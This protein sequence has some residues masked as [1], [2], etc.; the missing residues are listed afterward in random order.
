M[1]RVFPII[2]LLW[3][4][5]SL[6][7][8]CLPT[9][10]AE[11]DVNNMRVGL[12]NG[13]DMWWD[14][15]VP[16]CEFPKAV[17]IGSAYPKTIIDC[18][19]LWLSGIDNKLDLRLVAQVYRNG[20]DFFPGA[21]SQPQTT[22]NFFNR[23]FKISNDSVAFHIALVQANNGLAPPQLIPKQIIEWPARGNPHLAAQGQGITN[24][25]APFEDTD[26]NGIYEPAK[27]DYPLVKG[28]EAFWCVINDAG[29]HTST[30][31]LSM[32]VEV[33]I[34]AYAFS[35]NG[36]SPLNDATFYEY[37]VT[38]KSE[39]TYN[40]FYVSKWIAVK[41]WY[42][43]DSYETYV[44]CDSLNDLAFWSVPKSPMFFAG[45]KILGITQNKNEVKR[46]L[47]SFLVY[48][49]ENSGARGMPVSA[50]QYRYNQLGR[51]LD[52]TP[53]TFGGNGYGG[54]APTNFMFHGNPSSP[55]QWSECHNLVVGSNSPGFRR[56][57]MNSGPFVFPPNNVI[58]YSFVVFGKV[59][60]V[61]VCHNV[62]QN[63][64]PTANF[65]QNYYNAFLKPHNL[66]S[67][68]FN[69]SAQVSLEVVLRPNP[70]TQQRF[71]INCSGCN[72]SE[73][74]VQDLNGRA[75]EITQHKNLEDGYE[76]M[77]EKHV[78]NG[79]YIVFDKTNPRLRAKL[80]VR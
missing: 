31:A 60:D 80:I 9:A 71:S 67:N 43:K 59:G 4:F 20:N 25:L 57:L 12:L 65:L 10:K 47:N 58:T 8:N 29:I 73:W 33:Q 39:R 52:N 69:E 13:G 46:K 36:T 72:I 76:V 64:L 56:F 35:M 17:P 77:F 66:V 34:L 23:F 75:L 15:S 54:S 62:E 6:A 30:N 51:W 61:G 49:S 28:T 45:A 50:P 48:G 19:G 41:G 55:F 40:Q 27:G 26:G 79:V 5:F 68:S 22:C 7:Q 1:A 37:K 78:P 24:D 18:G 32:D 2:L 70:S 53:M 42:Y 44:G 11:L 21:L 3:N 74:V 14:L 63:I 16:K 38:N